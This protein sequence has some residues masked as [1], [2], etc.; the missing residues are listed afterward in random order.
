MSLKISSPVLLHFYILLKK[1]PQVLQLIFSFLFLLTGDLNMQCVRT[2]THTHRV[3]RHTWAL[4]DWSLSISHVQTMVPVRPGTEKPRCCLC[5][6][7]HRPS[8]PAEEY[9]VS[10]FSTF[11]SFTVDGDDVFGVGR[12]PLPH[13]GRVIQHVPMF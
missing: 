9:Q 7:L 3:K 12:H 5:P 4:S 6:T 13:I 8:Q 10:P 2:H 11:P 1:L